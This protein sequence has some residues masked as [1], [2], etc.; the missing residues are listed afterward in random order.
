MGFLGGVKPLYNKKQ[1]RFR[2][3]KDSSAMKDLLGKE[4]VSKVLDRASERQE[5]Y[6]R[7]K[8]NASGRGVT[9]NTIR[10][11]LGDFRQS[12]GNT[13]DKK[14]ASQLAKALVSGHGFS[15]KPYIFTKE[16]S[17][18][19]KVDRV[20]A[21]RAGFQERRNNLNAKLKNDGKELKTDN[22]VKLNS[23]RNSDE[24]IDLKKL[25]SKH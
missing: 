18:R 19:P 20:E 8:E 13:I 7:L 3:A 16:K 24:S 9:K 6:D 22:V 17:A 11:T 12:R 10:K 5:F 1:L 15:R 23:I 4:G 21:L 25:L 14:E 2:K